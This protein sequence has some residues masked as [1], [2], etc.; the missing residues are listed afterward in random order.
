MSEKVTGK[1]S[2]ALAYFSA[3]LAFIS[4]TVLGLFVA[5][6][7]LA[8]GNVADRLFA[9]EMVYLQLLFLT[10]LVPSLAFCSYLALGLQLTSRF[11]RFALTCAAAALLLVFP[12]VSPLG[13]YTLWLRRKA[14][15]K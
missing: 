5:Q 3:L 13:L 14:H 1:N 10:M 11:F 7:S 6:L 8:E 4:V 2:N 12:L 15:H 9:R